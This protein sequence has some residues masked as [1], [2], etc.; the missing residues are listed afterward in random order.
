[1]WYKPDRNHDGEEPD[2][3]DPYFDLKTMPASKG[4]TIRIKSF[5]IDNKLRKNSTKPKE[6]VRIN[7]TKKS[8]LKKYTWGE[9]LALNIK[10]LNKEEIETYLDDD[11]N[12]APYYDFYYEDVGGKGGELHIVRKKDAE[13]E[14]IIVNNRT[15][16]KKKEMGG[17]KLKN[18]TYYFTDKNGKILLNPR[19][20]GIALTPEEITEYKDFINRLTEENQ[21]VDFADPRT[22][23]AEKS[24]E[25]TGD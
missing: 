5:D 20:K 23:Q 6:T 2:S 11:I 17:I 24:T 4:G 9:L 13:I 1:M 3:K 18:N 7:G 12:N 14:D 22:S 16:E 19:R 8:G 10:D 15:V 25:E 21:W